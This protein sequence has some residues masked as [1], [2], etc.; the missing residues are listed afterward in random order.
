M[1]LI[2]PVKER[3]NDIQV[4]YIFP[5]I[6]FKYIIMI[7]GESDAILLFRIS[8]FALVEVL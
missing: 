8:Y 5:V 4:D 7:I 6:Y 2:N 3:Q 1:Y